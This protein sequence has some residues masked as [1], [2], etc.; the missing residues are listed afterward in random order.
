MGHEKVSINLPS[1]INKV[2]KEGKN[3]VWSCVPLDG[4]T[5]KSNTGFNSSPLKSFGSEIL[6]FFQ[7][8]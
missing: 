4:I 1:I 7:I 2:H 5:V 6:K 3:V 8:D